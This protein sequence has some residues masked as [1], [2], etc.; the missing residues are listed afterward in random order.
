MGWIKRLLYGVLIGIASI[1]PGLSGGTIA[2]A[3]GFYEKLITAVA[4]ILKDFR[5]HFSYLLPFGLGAVVSIAALSVIF[6]Y[7]FAEFPLPTNMLFIGFIL[8][9]LPFIRGR[10]K[11]SLDDRKSSWKHILVGVIFLIIVLLPVFIAVPSADLSNT[12]GNGSMLMFFMIGMIIA[13]TLVIPGL[14]GTMIL[15]AAGFYKPLLNT[16]SSFV[17]SVVTFD[18]SGAASLLVS[19]I[20]L[21][22]GVLLGGILIAK[23]LNMLF[24]IIPSYIYAAVIGLIFATPVVM[25]SEIQLSELSAASVSAGIIALAAGLFLGWKLG[26]HDK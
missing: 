19:I 21:G 26:E 22:I 10:F 7:M 11:S 12:Q 20:P 17:T 13:A 3:L 5:K 4:D 14:S 15:T 23:L 24:R 18:F 9:T 1:A 16:A 8:G 2:I 25:L 6:D